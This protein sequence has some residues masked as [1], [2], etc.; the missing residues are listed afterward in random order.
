MYVIS[1]QLESFFNHTNGLNRVTLAL[2]LGL[3][4]VNTHSLV[5]SNNPASP[6]IHH[7]AVSVE[8]DQISNIEKILFD[9]VPGYRALYSRAW[10]RTLHLYEK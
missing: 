5:P 4:F 6:V 9:I 8:T 1:E 3:G 2:L 7:A 10:I